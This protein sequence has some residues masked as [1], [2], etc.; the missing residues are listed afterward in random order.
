MLP[1]HMA[2]IPSTRVP[3]G[4]AW[5]WKAKPAVGIG[6]RMNALKILGNFETCQGRRRPPAAAPNGPMWLE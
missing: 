5:G 2:P 4:Y 3:A 1:S 6:P